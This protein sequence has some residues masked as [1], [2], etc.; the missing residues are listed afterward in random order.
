M[1]GRKSTLAPA[2][3][4]AHGA[5]P[6]LLQ[7]QARALQGGRTRRACTASTA[8]AAAAASPAS[9]AATVQDL[10]VEQRERAQQQEQQDKQQQRQQGQPHQQQPLDGV[11]GPDGVRVSLLTATG[12]DGVSPMPQPHPDAA[13]LFRPERFETV[14]KIGE[15]LGAGTYGTVRVCTHRETGERFAVKMLQRRRNKTDRTQNI[16]NEA[17]MAHRVR[18]CRSVVRTRAVHTDSYTVYLVQDLAAGGSLQAQ[19]GRAHV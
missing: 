9:V 16:Y 14:Y 19:I 10:D 17:A 3:R 1:L 7:L 2:A 11:R 8:A 12:A 15:V 13:P 5:G 18:W 6:C 4:A